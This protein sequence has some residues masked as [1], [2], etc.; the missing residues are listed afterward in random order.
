MVAL[1]FDP[2]QVTGDQRIADRLVDQ[3]AE[4]MRAMSYDL[5]HGT[6]SLEDWHTRMRDA[7]RLAYLEQAIAASPELDERYITDAD[8]RRIEAEIERQYQF[9]DKFAADIE[10]AV[11]KPGA[12]LE[13]VMNR[14]S[15]YAHS[16]G[17][18]YWRQA[19]DIELPAIPRDYSTQCG[20]RCACAWELDCDDAGRVHAT[21]VL[22]EADHCPD[23]VERARTWVDLIIP[24]KK[25]TA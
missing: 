20:S 4:R 7:I 5:V 22:G 17:A 18:E 14:A 15:L 6:L 2:C 13:F 11:L 12:S 8:M 16:S 1:S 24:K 9:L 19:I 10:A 21:W 25:R 23:C 3:F